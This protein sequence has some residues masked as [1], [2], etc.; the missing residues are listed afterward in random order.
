[1]NLPDGEYEINAVLESR[2]DKDELYRQCVNAM[3]TGVSD[4]VADANRQIRET[5]RVFGI[6][7][8]DGLLVLLHGR[9]KVLNPDVILMRVG[10]RLAKK[11]SEGNPQ[12]VQGLGDASVAQTRVANQWA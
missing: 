3:S 12:Y 7:E 11:T 1:M 6:D 9:V 2:T 4:G 5:K 10:Q 8:A